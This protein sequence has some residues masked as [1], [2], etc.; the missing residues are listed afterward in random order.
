MT[1]RLVI[2]RHGSAAMNAPSDALRPLTEAGE[3]EAHNASR[4]FPFEP[5]LI[6]HSPLLR[7]E[8]TARILSSYY[9]HAT[10]IQADWLVPEAVPYKVIDQLETLSDDVALVSHQ[11]LVSALAALLLQGSIRYT[12]EVPFLRP[13]NFLH[14][15]MAVLAPG[16]ADLVDTYL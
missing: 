3:V 1:K 5:S 7:A 10:L 6:F 13:A 11:P 14:L 4:A 16:C 9:P 15:Q 8:Q 12:Q 2:M